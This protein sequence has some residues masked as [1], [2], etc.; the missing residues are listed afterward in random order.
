MANLEIQIGADSSELNAEISAA[1]SKIKRL[2]AL[3]V[4]RVKLGLDVKELNADISQAKQQLAS[5]NKATQSTGQSF[6]AMTPKVANGGNALMQFSRIAQDA[7]YGIIG[8]GNN[9]TATV[10]AFGHLKNSTGSTGGALKA[11]AGSIMGSGGILLA[12]SLV[13]TAFTYMAQNGLTLGDVVGKITG[14]FNEARKAAQEMNA[15]IAGDSQGQI[16][17][18]NAY[19]SAAQNVNLSMSDRL[20]AV[21]KLQD[22]YPGYFGN[23]SKEQILNGDVAGAVREVT[24]ALIAKA[25][26]TAAVDKIVKL[27]EEEERIQSK[28]KNE[29]AE[30]A[31]GY[32]LNKKEA[33]DFTKA[34]LEGADAFKLLDPYKKRAGFFDVANAVS[35]NDS[36]KSLNNE[37]V[38]NRKN[39]DKLTESINNSTA[40]YVKLEA[41]SIKSPKKVKEQ[42]VFFTPQVSGV[43]S[44]LDTKGLIDVNTIAVQT[45]A[46]DKF[47]NK[48]KELPGII[49]TSMGEVRTEFD[50]GGLGVL[51]ALAGF[52][53]S[54]GSIITSGTVNALAG[55]GE[56]LGAALANGGNVIDAV[57]KSI[58]GSMGAMLKELG[59]ATIAYGVGLIA[60]KTAIKNPATAIAA[61]VAMVALGSMIS[62]SISK[63]SSS[64]LG[65]GDSGGSRSV[66]GGNSVSSPTSSTSS[67]G[68]SGFSGG[69][70][71]FEISGQSLIGV[72]GN[73][74]DKNRRLGGSLGLG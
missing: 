45:G 47:G 32:Q 31:R 9:I 19:V 52:N 8:I 70:V 30:V 73:T 25:K 33:F 11:L 57:S 58:L 7:P 4:E 36:L 63:S 15:K 54:L 56:S 48:I 39:Q 50:T 37:L 44:S 43:E 67:S 13:T 51:E 6:S 42:K 17:G 35:F 65:G 40:A 5:L 21:K 46:I 29:L 2:G 72:L 10:E 23:L 34:V 41:P 26:A 24:K 68:S 62:S 74:L 22:E 16:S 71:V 59:K 55:I 49:R 61:G 1:E 28:I 60:I 12:V 18:M 64:A 3:K 69:T 38:S 14:S 27:A 53:E 66:S 20:I